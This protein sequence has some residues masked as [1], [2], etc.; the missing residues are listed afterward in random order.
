MINMDQPMLRAEVFL[1]LW[2]LNQKEIENATCK[3]KNNELGEKA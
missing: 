1:F 3:I 2:N